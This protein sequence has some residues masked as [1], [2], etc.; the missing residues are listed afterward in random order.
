MSDTSFT[1]AGRTTRVSGS[2]VAVILYVVAD[3]CVSLGQAFSAMQQADWD[4][5]WA[6]QR[7]GFFLSQIG[8]TAL[9]VKAFYSGSSPA[10]PTK[11]TL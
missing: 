6:L 9:I 3:A 8:S 7:V 5:M 10:T 1:F 2:F 11:P 4:S